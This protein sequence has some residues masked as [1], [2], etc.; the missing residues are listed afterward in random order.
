MK[1]KKQA[2]NINIYENMFEN[3]FKGCSLP[4]DENICDS[5]AITIQQ[6]RDKNVLICGLGVSGLGAYD[7]LKILN[8]NI[9]VYATDFS[10][11]SNDKDVVC[12]EKLTP[13][14][15]QDMDLIILSPTTRLSKK[16]SK[17][18]VEQK[19]ECIGE[20][21]FGYRLCPAPIF[22]VT[23]T[24]GKTTTATLLNEMI[25]TTYNS[26]ALGNIGK[27][28]SQKALE[29]TKADR[30]VLECSSFQL[31]QTKSFRPHISALL[32]LAPDHLDFHKDIE[33]YFTAKLKIFDN[34]NKTDFAVINFDDNCCFERT[35]NILPQIYYFSTKQPCKGVFVQD[36]TI[37]F[38]DGIITYAI[39]RLDKLHYVGEHNLSNMLC[40]T[41]VAIL[42]GV[43]IENIATI[44][45]NFHTP[46]HRLEFV[47]RLQNVD[48]YNDSKA[49]NIEGCL[50]ACNAIRKPINLL[51]G[52]SD[53]GENFCIL[54][55]HLPSNVQWIYLFGKTQRK[56]Y[57]A[58]KKRHDVQVFRCETLISATKFASLKAKSG[59]VVLLSPA[60]ASFDAFKNYEERGNLF[61]QIVN[62]LQK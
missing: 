22:A 12:V 51:L 11:I 33:E 54:A 13:K 16:M 44:L 3:E 25:A 38:S 39:T 19:I 37:M 1:N 46:P 26:F 20:I 58:L 10:P 52:G 14:I 40:A 43:S 62:D 48:Y 9:Y 2:T 61:K 41:C 55:Q 32:N 28:F 29:L 56:L 5:N 27:S 30:V 45:S 50:T 7:A 21:E 31:A 36:E 49:T 47:R 35:K 34:M 18:I 60:C 23:G 8:A 15:V 17:F 24:N 53:K 59:E 42:A 4:N 57:R 6:Y